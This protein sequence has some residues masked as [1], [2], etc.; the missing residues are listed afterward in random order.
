MKYSSFS[1]DLVLVKKRNHNYFFVVEKVGA[2]NY[3]VGLANIN[4]FRLIFWLSYNPGCSAKFAKF[5]Y[6]YLIIK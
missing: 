1:F 6:K 5:L 2:I 4:Y 3:K